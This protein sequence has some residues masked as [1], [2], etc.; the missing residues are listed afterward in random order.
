MAFNRRC[1]KPILVRRFHQKHIQDK[2]FNSISESISKAQ[3]NSLNHELSFT[4][5]KQNPL[6]GLLKTLLKLNHPM[7]SLQHFFSLELFQAWLPPLADFIWL[8]PSWQTSYKRG[9]IGWAFCFF[10]PFGFSYDHLNCQTAVQI[11]P[12]LFTVMKQNA[13]EG[14]CS[15]EHRQMCI[16]LRSECQIYLCCLSELQ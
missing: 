7:C 1:P 4:W 6:S 3:Y 8:S 5:R 13:R 2:I 14:M 15:R 11:V 12:T 10:I 16:L 9:K